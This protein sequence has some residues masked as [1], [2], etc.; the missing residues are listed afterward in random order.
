MFLQ[1]VGAVELGDP[2]TLPG[3]GASTVTALTPRNLAERKT[4]IIAL[5]PKHLTN[6]KTTIIAQLKKKTIIAPIRRNLKER[7]TT[8]I[9][10]IPKKLKERKTTIIALTQRH[11]TGRKKL[12]WYIAHKTILLKKTITAKTL[13]NL[14]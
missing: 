9:A 2:L 5:I 11:L 6:R 14:A 7:K 12:P 1:A 4:T 13:R 8:I 10:L 3:A